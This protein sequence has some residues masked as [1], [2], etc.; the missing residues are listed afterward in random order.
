MLAASLSALW[1]VVAAR[2]LSLLNYGDFTQVISLSVILTAA[3]DLGLSMLL[4][5]DVAMW[6]EGS[7][8]S[9]AR[10]TALRVAVGVPACVAMTGLYWLAAA[11]PTVLV[12]ALAAVSM[13]ATM[14]H[15]T[16][17]VAARG[18]GNVRPEALNEVASRAFVLLVGLGALLAWN[19]VAAAVAVYA[20]A[21]V[22]SAVALR[23]FVVRLMP[24][25]GRSQTLGFPLRR[26]AL[27]G[28]TVAMMT[29][30]SR[31]DLWLIGVMRSSAEVA[32]YAAPYRL[33]E[34]VLLVAS[35]FAALTPPLMAR[36]TWSDTMSGLRRVVG[37]AAVTTGAAAAI[38]MVISGPLMRLL[39]GSRY[40]GTETTLRIL[41]L[42]AVPSAIV[43]VLIQGAGLL[44]RR[45]AA[46][47][48]CRR[49][50]REHCWQPR[51]DPAGWNQWSSHGDARYPVGA[52]R[53]SGAGDPFREGKTRVAGS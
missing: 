46:I 50:R 51:R 13:I 45:G 20:I 40:A 3:A 6:P 34:G 33:F 9:L 15:Q 26:V 52:R 31:A 11:N 24:P 12:A 16:I 30:Y 25:R 4:A 38:G 44:H 10:V 47:R 27:L 48:G 14:V 32:R 5:H 8:E 49:A 35:T 17:S 37:A 53:G 2:H 29:L 7:R 23:L 36:A 39:Y 43:L 1:L 42:A 28:V 22:L 19:S 18:L 21:D 41:L